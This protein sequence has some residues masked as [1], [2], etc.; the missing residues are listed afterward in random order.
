[1][2]EPVNPIHPDYYLSKSS[3]GFSCLNSIE[4]AIGQKGFEDYCVGCI[5]KYLFRFR[6]KN[7]VVDLQKAENYLRILIKSYS[8]K[9][10]G[11][12]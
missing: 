1:M 3:D 7:G 10:Q 4:S 8:R 6:E 5:V 2:T 11:D 9:G 12:V